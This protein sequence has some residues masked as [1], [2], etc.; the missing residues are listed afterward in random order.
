MLEWVHL[1]EDQLVNRQDFKAHTTVLSAI[2]TVFSS[3]ASS[4]YVDPER[5]DLVIAVEHDKDNPD[6][7]FRVEVWRQSA[8]E[9]SDS[10]TAHVGR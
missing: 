8:E 10:D 6:N 9:S 5:I 3:I 4:S 7:G 1:A 2:R